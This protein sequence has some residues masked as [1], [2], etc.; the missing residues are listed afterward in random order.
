[1]NSKVIRFLAVFIAFASC[2][3]AFAQESDSNKKKN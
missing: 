3:S 2:G 1:M